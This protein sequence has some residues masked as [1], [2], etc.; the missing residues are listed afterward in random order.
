MCSNGLSSRKTFVSGKGVESNFVYSASSCSVSFV[1][2]FSPSDL[3]SDFIPLNVFQR[4]KF[5]KDICQ[6]EGGR[7]QLCVFRLFL[8]SELCQIFFT[9]RSDFR[10]YPIECV[11]TD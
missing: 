2:Y 10:F 8:F 4:T 11:P 3:I 6:W 5:E 9:F 7:E 1:K